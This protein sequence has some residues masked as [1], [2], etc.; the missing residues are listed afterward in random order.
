MSNRMIT[1]VTNYMNNSGYSLL[2]ALV[3]TVV[4]AIG[5]MGF[6]MLQASSIKT[7]AYSRRVTEATSLIQKKIESLS[8][9]PWNDPA[10]SDTNGNGGNATVNYGLNLK[11]AAADNSINEGYYTISWNV[12]DNIPFNNTKT[13]RFIATW[14]ESEGIKNV[15][16]DYIMAR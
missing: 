1:P 5:I 15:T 10:I 11:G 3:A 14:S 9:L 16:M 6:A 13:I 8:S 2:E 4:L 12:A 7:N